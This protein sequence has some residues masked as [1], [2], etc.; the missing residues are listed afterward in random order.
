MGCQHPGERFKFLCVMTTKIYSSS[1]VHNTSYKGCLLCTFQQTA[2][3]ISMPCQ[4][5]HLPHIHNIRISSVKWV[6]KPFSNSLALFN[7]IWVI[8][9]WSHHHSTH[10]YHISLHRKWE[11][12]RNA[13]RSFIMGVLV[14]SGRL[15]STVYQ[16]YH[17]DMCHSSLTVWMLKLDSL[18]YLS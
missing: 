5:L 13:G 4:P 7:W 17:R 8:H 11:G 18:K 9:H 2:I 14:F 1:L 10:P 15:N 16:I 3:P 6:P 12:G